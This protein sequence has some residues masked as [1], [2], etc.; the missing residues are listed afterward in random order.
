MKK[1]TAIIID[2]IEQARTTLTQDLSTYSKDF[3]VIGEADGV[4]Q[5]AKL[6]KKMTPDILFLD[7]Q[8]QDG[9]GFDLLDLLGEINFKI[10]FI[11][12]SDAHAIQAFRYA[13]IDYLLKPIDPDELVDALDKFKV[14][15]VNE[16]D[17]Y[18]FLSERLKNHNK[19]TERL[20]LHSQERIQ[21]VE[22][23]NIIR[24]ESSVNYTTFF[25]QDKSQIV[26]TKTLK[27]FEDLL[28]SQGFF[29]VHQSHLVN[30]SFIKEYV[31]IDGGHLVLLDETLVPVSVRKRPE[32][33]KMLE[34]L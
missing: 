27:E 8:M 34:N 17:K 33:M 16:N 2:D 5:G 13:A 9:S 29:R 28:K 6:L 21:I 24:C 7:I 22:I 11:T 12:A 26:V 30:T 19:P 31:K 32:V 20:A 1:Y 18:Q 23:K 10:I 15:S 4:V 3:E 25:F 14:S